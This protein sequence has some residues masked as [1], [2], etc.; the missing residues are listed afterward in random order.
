M[1]PPL[2]PGLRVHRSNLAAGNRPHPLQPSSVQGLLALRPLLNAKVFQL[3]LQLHRHALHC[4]VPF[5]FVQLHQLL[6]KNPLH[7]RECNNWWSL[8]D[9]VPLW[10]LHHQLLLLLLLPLLLHRP[11][12]RRSL[13]LPFHNLQDLLP[14]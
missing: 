11:Y 6:Y 10:L 2:L 1:L 12:L 9:P 13:S 4:P 14:H 7:H 8:Y 5:Q 3:R